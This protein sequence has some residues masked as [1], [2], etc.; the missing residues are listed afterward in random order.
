MVTQATSG[1][2]KDTTPSGTGPSVT[3]PPFSTEQRTCLQGVFGAASLSSYSVPIIPGAM[4]ANSQP[5]TSMDNCA[6]TI[7]CLPVGF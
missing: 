5:G 3:V 4:A 1:P 7:V 6:H 2:S